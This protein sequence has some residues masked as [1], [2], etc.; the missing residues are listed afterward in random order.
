VIRP[1]IRRRIETA[2]E[3]AEAWESVMSAVAYTAAGIIGILAVIMIISAGNK[4]GLL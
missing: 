4:F 3:L 2:M 1:A